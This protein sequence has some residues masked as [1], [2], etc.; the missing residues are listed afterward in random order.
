MVGDILYCNC[1]CNLL[2]HS[3]VCQRFIGETSKITR[4]VFWEFITCNGPRPILTLFSLE[5]AHCARADFNEL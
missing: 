5:R 3:G 4:R 1:N 2:H